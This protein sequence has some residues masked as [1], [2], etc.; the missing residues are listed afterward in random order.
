[1]TL[2]FAL[3]ANTFCEIFTC[4]FYYRRAQNLRRNCTLGHWA[5]LVAASR[6]HTC[7]DLPLKNQLTHIMKFYVC[8][9]LHTCMG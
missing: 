6:L 1:M 7:E 4:S 9:K 5:N 8:G 2:L 3:E